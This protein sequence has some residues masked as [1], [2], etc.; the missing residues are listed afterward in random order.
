MCICGRKWGGRG[1]CAIH[2]LV[3]LTKVQFT[4]IYSGLTLVDSRA[5][6]NL[7]L[8]A[9]R[10]KLEFRHSELVGYTVNSQLR[11]D[12]LPLISA[13]VCTYSRGRLVAETVS[14]ILANTHPNFELVVVDQSKDDQTA[15]ALQAFCADA[16]LKYVKSS[17]IG[18][19]DALN[20][21]LNATSGSII[22]ITDDDCTVP[23]GWLETFA[24]IFD[25][26]SNVAVA[27]CCVEAGEH[28]RAAGFVP[29]YIR[30]EDRMLTSMHDARHVRGLGAGIAVRRDMIEELGGFDPMLGPGSK[31]HDCDD[32][33][34]AI[35]ALLAR[36]Q[37]Y[38]TS[39]IAVKHFGFRSWKE[40]PQLARRNF[41]G[42]GATY[43]KFL[44]CGYLQLMY[45]PAY[46][47]MRYALWPPVSDLLHLR[48][49]RGFVRI[50]AFAAGFLHGLR[51]PVDRATMMFVKG[52]KD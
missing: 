38:E 27:F 11:Q 24:S 40:G 35:R 37:V 28:D 44:K 22:A 8:Q 26:H 34:I 9:N 14:S 23:P 49:P 20:A 17:T 5:G 4:A 16:R 6:R 7:A 1:E 50:T 45:L 31:F 13:L 21:G 43:S 10:R 19:G 46:E 3:A 12:D 18:K 36:H 42:I 51:T 48:R 29:D 39:A 33:D 52:R 41:F 32:R 47:F 30:V 15:E 2:Q 25:L